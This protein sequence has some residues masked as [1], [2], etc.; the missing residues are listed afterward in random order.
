MPRLHKA[1]L[2]T[3]F[4]EHDKYI[5]VK[6]GEAARIGAFDFESAFLTPFKTMF[7]QLTE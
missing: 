2:H 5:G 6:P 4:A 3:Y 1:K 7:L